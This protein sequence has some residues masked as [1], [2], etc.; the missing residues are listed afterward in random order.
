MRHFI[1]LLLTLVTCLGLPQS[2]FATNNTFEDILLQA[3]EEDKHIFMHFTASWCL[4]CQMINDQLESHPEILK[5]INEI[6][7]E[8]ELDYDEPNDQEWFVRYGV[9]CLPTM[10]VID[11]V[12]QI[13]DRMD[14]TGSLAEIESFLHRNS[15]Y[16]TEKSTTKDLSNI[17]PPSSK[18][19][20]SKK[21]VK[22]VK[23]VFEASD[24]SIQFGAFSSYENAQKLSS[25]LFSTESINTII[26]E[27]SSNGK[28][29]YKVRQITFLENKAGSFYVQAYKKKGID[30]MLKKV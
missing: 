12:G 4:P 9:Q 1:P 7:I 20:I 22:A 17:M 26:L 21:N 29:L 14:G 5:E 27:E 16:P 25:I 23:K 24:F 11:D 19:H 2:S 30:C 18:N 3:Q 6:Y 8:L 10:I 13:I 15:K 28:T